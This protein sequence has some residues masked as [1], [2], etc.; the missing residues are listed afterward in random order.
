M[1]YLATIY[2]NRN[3]AQS[4]PHGKD[5]IRLAYFPMESFFN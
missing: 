3:G 2:V 4:N 1:T 5:I